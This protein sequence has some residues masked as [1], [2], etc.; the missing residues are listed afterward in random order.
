[1]TAVLIVPV[2]FATTGN[3]S[4]MAYA[5]GMIMLL[6]VA[7]CLNEFA[8]RSTTSGS[9]YAYVTRGM[10]SVG[11]GL[12]GWCLIWAYLFIGLA[13]LTGFTN[14]AEVLLGM[15]GVPASMLS[16]LWMSL[17]CCAVCL[18]I[19]YILAFKDVRLSAVLMLVLEAVSI[20]LIVALAFIVL[21][22]KGF[23][24]D[25]DQLTMKGTSFSQLGFG[26]VVAIFSL[27]GFEAATAF[28]DEA[29]APLVNI[30]KAVIWSLIL[31]GAFFV[32]ITY[33]EVYG[34][35]GNSTTLDQLTAP[36][37]TLATQ[38]HVGWLGVPVSIGAMVSFFS[39]NLS[40][41]N[42][43]AR[44]MYKMGSHKVFHEAVGQTHSKNATPHVAATVVAIMM[45]V[46]ITGMFIWH[47]NDTDLFGYVGTFG[48]FGF[49]GAYYLVSIA[50]PMYLKKIGELQPKHI[51]VSAIAVLLLTVPAIGSVYTNPPLTAPVKYFVYIFLS[52]FVVGLV[53]CL[54]Q[55]GRSSEVMES[56]TKDLELPAHGSAALPA[57]QTSA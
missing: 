24:I 3:G 42:S 50:A 35:R 13:G 10:G 32:F 44:V 17:L 38:Y 37:N 31:T 14:F 55:R 48:A 36:L 41:M 7:L 21:F 29:K 16:S 30:P 52:Y 33:M 47:N 11:G 39:L 2:M 46:V 8:K 25:H 19:S 18:G 1:M 5:F 51:V 4:W 43:G 57:E 9:M 49:L 12:T 22:H 23:P 34:T 28:G 15:M 54:M 20:A 27:V 45:G 26:V 40:C 6:F 56:V 53:M